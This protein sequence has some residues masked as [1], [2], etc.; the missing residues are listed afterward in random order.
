MSATVAQLKDHFTGM[1]GGAS[2]DDVVNLYALMERVANT[3]LARLDPI[4]TERKQQLSQA[5]HDDLQNYPLPSDYKKVI[6]LAPQDDRQS[7]DRV[8]RRYMEPF[9]AEIG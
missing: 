6:D 4:E 9:A 8:Q 3:V 1:G 7:K 2:I 5:V